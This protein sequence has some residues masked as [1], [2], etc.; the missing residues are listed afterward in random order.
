MIHNDN[1][2]QAFDIKTGETLWKREDLTLGTDFGKALLGMED[3]REEEII[4][5]S[6]AFKGILRLDLE[7]MQLLGHTSAQA[8]WKKTKDNRNVTLDPYHFFMDNAGNYIYKIEKGELT[9]YRAE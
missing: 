7:N 4:Y 5:Q 2:L 8:R 6:E 9:R 3:A 1:G